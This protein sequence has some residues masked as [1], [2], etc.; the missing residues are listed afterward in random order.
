[1]HGDSAQLLRGMAGVSTVTPVRT[2]W[3]TA[4]GDE[5]A[6]GAAAA[7]GIAPEP[8]SPAARPVTVAVLDTGIDT[9]HPAVAGR[10]N[11]PH[12]ATASSEG[13]STAGTAG[14]A[15]AAG[16]TID[17][18]PHGTAVAPRSRC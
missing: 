3:P 1:V 10:V 6:V 8:A 4:I 9:T 14:A 16:T 17:A 12:D 2:M 13:G 5:G 7:A 11:A 18:D 15:A